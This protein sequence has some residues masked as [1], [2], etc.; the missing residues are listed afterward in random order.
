MEVEV[1]E[2][3]KLTVH[4][5]HELLVKK[6]ISSEELVKAILKR[7]EEI[8]E[9]VKAYITVDEEKAL[10]ASRNIDKAGNFTSSLS[11]IPVAIK[12]NICT[13]DLKTTC[14][15]KMLENFIPP[16]DATGV[17][18]LKQDDAIVVGKT[19]LDEFAMGSSTENSA[20]FTTKNPW[21]LERV[22]GG[23]SGGSAASVAADECIFALGSDTGGSI[24][25]PASCCGVVGLKPTYGR[26]SRYGLAEMASSLDQV[27][28]ITKDVTDSAIILKAIAGLDEL[29]STTA[30]LPVPDY[31]KSLVPD[32]KGIKIGIVKEY[33]DYEI[34][35]EVRETIANAAKTLE[36]LGANIVEI[37]IPHIE[38]AIWAYHVISTA[39]ISSNMARY[40]GIRYGKRAKRYEDLIDLYRQS[41]TEGFG[42]EVKRRIMLGNYFLSADN[43][44]KYYIKAQKVRT[45]I[46]RDFDTAF[47]E[48]DLIISPTAPTVAFKIGEEVDDPIKMYMND[49]WTVPVNLAGLPGMS[50]PCGFSENLPIGLQIIGKAFN[51]AEMIKAA[52]AFEQA[53]DFWKKR[54]AI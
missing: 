11:G 25:Q 33:M 54:P 35:G 22:P 36:E 16:Y 8:D 50:I 9:K 6:Q 1:L 32:V 40:D 14:S 23:S 15:S 4:E 41:R 39:E 48:C 24:R 46:K 30:H 31:T 12:D 10:E 45:L 19:N 34:D 53:T 2:L 20:F 52:F 26:V 42:P 43:E 13:K 49:A 17:A 5:A 3:Y 28:I 38:Y 21:D 47:E 18:R 27:G 51:E 37:S 29:D 44:D 7:I